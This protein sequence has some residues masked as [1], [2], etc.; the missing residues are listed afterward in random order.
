MEILELPIKCDV[1]GTPY[2]S[3]P[4]SGVCP[5]CGDA[6]GPDRNVRL[7]LDSICCLSCGFV[8]AIAWGTPEAPAP[9]DEV[10]YFHLLE[11]PG[12]EISY[13]ADFVPG[14]RPVSDLEL[15]VGE[16]YKLGRRDGVRALRG[17]IMKLLNDE[18][19]R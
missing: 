16:A 2:A 17:K 19:P 10:V 13:P 9:F 8:R 5:S 7:R 4:A 6:P 14:M 3:F 18:L 11:C 1:C 15:R 12:H